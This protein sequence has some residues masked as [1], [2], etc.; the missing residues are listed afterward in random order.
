ME[1]FDFCIY[2]RNRQIVALFFYSKLFENFIICQ[3]YEIFR[4]LNQLLKF[5]YFH[6]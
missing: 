5:R 3:F 2:L 6:N 4:F 1:I